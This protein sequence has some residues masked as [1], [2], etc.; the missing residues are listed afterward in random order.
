MENYYCTGARL[1]SVQCKYVCLTICNFSHETGIF[2][3]QGNDRIIEEKSD[4]QGGGN[5][6][7]Q[8]WKERVINMF[9]VNLVHL[10]E[11]LVR[12]WKYE[13]GPVGGYGAMGSRVCN[14][15]QK[16]FNFMISLTFFI[17]EV[18]FPY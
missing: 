1:Y 17:I 11:T 10:M 15:H 16:I 18:C 6:K 7:N 14:R 12:D 13:I 9:D 8:S 4:E 5:T 2:L 3:R